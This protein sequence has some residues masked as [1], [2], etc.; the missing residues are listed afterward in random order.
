MDK[1]VCQSASSTAA[2]YGS[3]VCASL[4]RD[5]TFENPAR[6]LPG[7]T[8]VLLQHLEQA[9]GAHA[10]AD[11]HGDDGILRLA[12]AAFDQRVAG[13]ARARHAVG[14][15]DRDG[16]AIDVDLLRIDAELVAAVDH[17]HGEGL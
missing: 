6:C 15:A 4:A 17:L 13:Q 16:A 14:M 1:G 8:A 10:A 3:R 2:A 11:A 9:G 12:A 5:D 7:T